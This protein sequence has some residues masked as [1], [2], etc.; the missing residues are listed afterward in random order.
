MI[1]STIAVKMLSTC[2]PDTLTMHS[3]G[4]LAARRAMGGVGLLEGGGWGRRLKGA[5]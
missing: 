2:A 5:L 3:R 4:V 1:A